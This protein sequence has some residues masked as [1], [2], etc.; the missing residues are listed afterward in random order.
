[1]YECMSSYFSYNLYLRDKSRSFFAHRTIF[2]KKCLHKH[3][4]SQNGGTPGYK[5][6][7]GRKKNY[8]PL[9]CMSRVFCIVCFGILKNVIF[10]VF[11][12]RGG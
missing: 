8:S 11:I 9:Q 7:C 3:F 10:P 1:M 2:C 12:R 4:F 5:Y 6:L